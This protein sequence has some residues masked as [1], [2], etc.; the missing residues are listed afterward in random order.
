MLNM[1][2]DQSLCSHLNLGT[3]ADCRLP[4]T[5]LSEA[6]M[7]SS[8]VLLVLLFAIVTGWYRLVFGN[9]QFGYL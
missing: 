3:L 4:T 7:D 9:K 8:F 5:G 6:E 2:Q 1:T